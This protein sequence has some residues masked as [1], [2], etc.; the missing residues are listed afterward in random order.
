CTTAS[1]WSGEEEAFKGPAPLKRISPKERVGER[2]FA[3]EPAQLGVSAG[4]GDG[5]CAYPVERLVPEAGVEPALG[6]NRTGF[7]VSRVCQFRHS[8]TRREPAVGQSATRTPRVRYR[9][10]MT[11]AKVGLAPKGKMR[12]SLVFERSSVSRISPA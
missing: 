1:S 8:G 11:L 10:L 2:A 7:W 12:G 5:S 6:V 3:R 9:V 4:G